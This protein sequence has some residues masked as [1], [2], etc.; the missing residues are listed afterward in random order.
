MQTII[1]QCQ[2]SN[3]SWLH[4]EKTMEALHLILPWTS[5]Y[6]LLSF[7]NFNLYPSPLINHNHEYNSFRWVLWVL[8]ANCWN[9]RVVLGTSELAIGICN[10]G[11]SMATVP[12]KLHSCPKSSHG[13]S[14]IFTAFGLE[15]TPCLGSDPLSFIGI[16]LINLFYILSRLGIYFSVGLIEHRSSVTHQPWK[17]RILSATSDLSQTLRGR[18]WGSTL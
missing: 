12:F 17:S 10:E 1:H 16:S 18:A 4:R 15:L 2:E 11:S 3:T 8:L 13:P 6:V 14:L 5:S 9:L 7:T